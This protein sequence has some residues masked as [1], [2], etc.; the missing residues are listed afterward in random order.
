MT[1][2]FPL[3][4][5][6]ALHEVAEL[7][8]VQVKVTK[9]G[10]IPLEG[11]GIRVTAGGC[12]TAVTVTPQSAETP[13]EV[14]VTVLTPGVEYWVLKFV[15]LPLDGVPPV[16]VHANVPVPP[17]ALRLAVVLTW[18]VWLAGEQTTGAAEIL[19]LLVVSL[20]TSLPFVQ[21]IV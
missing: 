19:T 18:T 3:H 11:F 1:L 21:I 15:P 20:T 5:S 7:F 10:Y 2:L 12:G 8:T 9:V 13:L 14:T 16:A 17:L 4:S 6:V